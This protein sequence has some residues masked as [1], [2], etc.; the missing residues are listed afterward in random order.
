MRPV[1]ELCFAS[2]R[3]T[4]STGATVMRISTTDA[5]P[6]VT[7][8]YETAQLNQ[9]YWDARTADLR[10]AV[11]AEYIVYLT[12]DFLNRVDGAFLASPQRPRC[13]PGLCQ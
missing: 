9:R 11:M 2:G 4:E 5:E 7:T 8:T 3:E 1:R 10:S 6:T 12:V 13:N